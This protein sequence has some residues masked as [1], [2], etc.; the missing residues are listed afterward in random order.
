MASRNGA[1]KWVIGGLVPDAI[2]R[3]VLQSVLVVIPVMV[4]VV[5]PAGGM[6]L[7]VERGAKIR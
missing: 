3:Y 1:S 4:D 2:G 7:L 5:R 6:I